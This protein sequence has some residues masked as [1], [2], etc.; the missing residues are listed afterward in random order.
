MEGS[1]MLRE[2]DGQSLI[3]PVRGVREVTN[4]TAAVIAADHVDGSDPYAA[5]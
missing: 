3:D 1:S 2:A 5:V 4:T